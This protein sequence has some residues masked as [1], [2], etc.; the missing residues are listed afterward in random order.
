MLEMYIDNIPIDKA[1]MNF[2]FCDTIK[3]MEEEVE[4]MKHYLYK[5]NFDKAFIAHQEPT[6]FLTAQ[7][8]A[9]E[10][11]ESDIDNLLVPDLEEELKIKRSKN[12]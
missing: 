4:D 1:E 5:Q 7:S 12:I 11:I 10:I 3:K 6:F 8:K 2:R 9:N